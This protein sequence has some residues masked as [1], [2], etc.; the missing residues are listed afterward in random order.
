MSPLL[1]SG[2]G[3]ARSLCEA[4]RPLADRRTALERA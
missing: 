1:G 2:G 3:W 4:Q